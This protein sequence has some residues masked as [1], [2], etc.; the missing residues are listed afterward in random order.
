MGATPPPPTNCNDVVPWL[1]QRAAAAFPPPQGLVALCAVGGAWEPCGCIRPTLPITPWRGVFASQGWR[2]HPPTPFPPLNHTPP[3]LHPPPRRLLL[4][5]RWPPAPPTHTSPS[6]PPRP[7]P[8]DSP[9][10]A[11]PPPP[12]SPRAHWVWRG[13]GGCGVRQSTTGWLADAASTSRRAAS[14]LPIAP[15]LSLHSAAG[16]FFVFALAQRLPGGLPPLP[17]S[18]SLS[19]PPSPLPPPPSLARVVAVFTRSA[20][21]TPHPSRQRGRRFWQWGS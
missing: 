1:A 9:N 13:G 7:A 6:P 14:A 20:V 12:P 18:A 5:A 4:R 19:L 15:H 3:P 21:V 11:Q 2:G 8:A 10:A 17:P 16:V